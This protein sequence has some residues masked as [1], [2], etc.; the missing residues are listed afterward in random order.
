MSLTPWLVQPGALL[1]SLVNTASGR[2]PGS[3]PH[4]E[5]SGPGHPHRL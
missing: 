3:A 4:V 1:L 2:R 5:G